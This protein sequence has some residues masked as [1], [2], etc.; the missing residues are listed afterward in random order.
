MPK[1]T[2]NAEGAIFVV[3]NRGEITAHYTEQFE[4]RL[5]AMLMLQALGA[6]TAAIRTKMQQLN[7]EKK[8]KL[9]E[10]ID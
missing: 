3:R 10:V 4:K 8:Q 9:A 7:T 5:Q 1:V 2:I 6:D